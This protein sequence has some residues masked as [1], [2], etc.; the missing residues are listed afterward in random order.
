MLDNTCPK[1]S[2]ALLGVGLLLLLVSCQKQA[3][4]TPPPP[5][6]Q[7]LSV[8]PLPRPTPLLGAEVAELVEI[9]TAEARQHYEQDALDKEQS[10]DRNQIVG[11]WSGTFDGRP[12]PRALPQFRFDPAVLW[13]VCFDIADDPSVRESAKRKAEKLRLRLLAERAIEEERY[14]HGRV[15]LARELLFD[16]D[17]DPTSKHAY[18]TPQAFMLMGDHDGLCRWYRWHLMQRQAAQLVNTHTGEQRSL[19]MINENM[20][21][22]WIRLARMEEDRSALVG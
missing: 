7:D 1:I 5:V 17:E 8:M 12:Q 4:D 18:K 14:A 19:A 16:L 13:A 15:L 6:K 22:Q 20:A 9:Y 11:I 10:R 3:V 21:E 2:S